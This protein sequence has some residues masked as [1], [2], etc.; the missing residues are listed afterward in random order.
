MR[1]FFKVMLTTAALLAPSALALGSGVASAAIT[2]AYVSPHGS[3]ARPD[4]SCKTAG[5]SSI[6]KAIGA[7]SAGGTVVVCRGTYRTQDVIRKPLSLEGLPGAVIN[8]KQYPAAQRRCG[9]GLQRHEFLP[10]RPQHRQVQWGR[11]LPRRRRHGP[12]QLRHVHLERGQP[13]PGRLPTGYSLGGACMPCCGAITSTAWWCAS[14]S[15]SRPTGR[16]DPGPAAFCPPAP[17][18]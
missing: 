13:Q 15:P 17:G 12:Q 4:T 9:R 14:G 6:N 3:S 11:R 8:A 1:T 7:V 5:F 10:G 18:A 2:T 16:G